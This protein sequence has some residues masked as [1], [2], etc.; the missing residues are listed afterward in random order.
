MPFICLT[1]GEMAIDGLEEAEVTVETS[2]KTL[3]SHSVVKA[4]SNHTGKV[5]RWVWKEERDLSPE[6]RAKFLTLK[7]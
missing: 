2:P 4:H 7:K 3:V 1:T 5:E 6:E